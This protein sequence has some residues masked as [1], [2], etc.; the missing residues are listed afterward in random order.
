MFNGKTHEISMA[1]SHRKL[2]VSH[3]QK[4]QQIRWR[5]PHDI[6][7]TSMALTRLL[8]QEIGDEV[9]VWKV[10]DQRRLRPR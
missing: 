1:I 7:M 8:H 10:E 3:Y 4:A 2:L 9:Q 6:L 5:I